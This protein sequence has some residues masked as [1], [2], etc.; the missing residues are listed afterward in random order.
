MPALILSTCGTSLL[1]NG[2]DDELRKLLNRHSNTSDWNDINQAEQTKLKQ[3]MDAREQALLAE[4]DIA[5]IKKQSAELNGL[6]TW[7]DNNPAIDPKDGQ[8]IFY[9]L[10]TDTILGDKT[11]QIIKQWL[12]KNGYQ[13]VQIITSS[14][15][16]TSNLTQF[17]NALRE[18]TKELTELF[19]GYKD[20]GYQ[21]YVN[22]TGGFKSL[23]GFLQALSGLY[24]DESFYLFEGSAEL[25]T[26]PKL[27][28]A[29]DNGVI[30]QNLTTFR[31]LEKGL[32]VDKQALSTIPDILLFGVDDDCMLSEWG[33]V[34]W[35]NYQNRAYKKT[36]LPSISDKV[37]FTDEFKQS[38]KD[39]DERIMT[40]VNKTIDELAVFAESNGEINLR[41]LDAKPLQQQQYR[42]QNLWECDIDIGHHRIF[43]QKQ[44]D[45]YVLKKAGT[46]LHNIRSSI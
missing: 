41:S 45:S 44:G 6:L 40:K 24:A 19:Q 27:P 33:E 4:T 3:H 42:E 35:A 16:K 36:L 22:L 1:A 38:C 9:L 34:L 5:K 20:S 2:V 8:T 29:L 26:I 25:L 31:R 7:Q 10:K 17:R 14:G 46:A 12:E 23:N 15:L 32:A 18:L 39:F 13:Q 11:A 43:M 30:E 28:I 37:V 21:I